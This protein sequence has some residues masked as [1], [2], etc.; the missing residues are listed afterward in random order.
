MSIDTDLFTLLGPLAGGRVYPDVAPTSTPRPYITYQKIGGQ[1]I[2]YTS[3]ELPAL[4]NS[5][6]QINVWADTRI[7]AA[8]LARQVEDALRQSITM[9]ARPEGEAMS[10]HEPDL[11]RYGTIQ[12]FSIWSPR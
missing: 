12:D 7:S 6:V 3:D 10:Q 4:Q 1:A 8:A 9:T 5:V 2:N 11:D